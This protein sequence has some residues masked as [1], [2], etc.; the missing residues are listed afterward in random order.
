MT[1]NYLP[2][3]TA[4]SRCVNCSYNWDGTEDIPCSRMRHILGGCGR[5][6]ETW[7]DRA[8]VCDFCRD[9]ELR[10]SPHARARGPRG[11]QSSS[12]NYYDDGFD[13]NEDQIYT[14]PRNSP[15]PF[16]EEES[17]RDQGRSRRN[18]N[19]SSAPHFH[20]D[21]YQDLEFMEERPWDAQRNEQVMERE[22]QRRE[23]RD[24]IEHE[25]RGGRTPPQPPCRRRPPQ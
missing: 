24:A 19:H 16:I 22:S 8:Y 10:L 7:A 12:R 21:Q 6:R 4:S 13:N 23:E 5:V 25:T 1:C 3:T 20:E 11:R 9:P 17:W 2:T 15:E 14:S 18:Q